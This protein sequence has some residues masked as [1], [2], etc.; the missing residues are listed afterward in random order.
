MKKIIML[1]SAVLMASFV[2]AAQ[3]KEFQIIL[4]GGP[5]FQAGTVTAITITAMDINDLKKDDF[6]GSVNI[7]STAGVIDVNG[8]GSCITTPFSSA[9]MDP[10]RW[11]G[12]IRLQGAASPTII[13]C[14]DSAGNLT[15]TSSA[16]QV[17]AGAF[18]KPLLIMDGMTWAP[19]TVLGYTGVAVTQTTTTPLFVTVL[20]V[21]A[22]NNTITSIF[23][24]VRITTNANHYSVTPTSVNMNVDLKAN[25]IFALALY[26]NPDTSAVY[27][28]NASNVTFTGAVTN[29]Q[30]V[31]FSSLSDYFVSA[32][33]PASAVAG[34]SFSVTVAVSH[35]APPYGIPISGL[36]D[37]V[38][39]AGI[40]FAGNSLNP[41]LQPV[42]EPN[43]SCTDGVKSF[44]VSYNK[45]SASDVT[46]IRISPFDI[47]RNANNAGLASR[48]SGVIVIY[49]DQPHSIEFTSALTKLKKGNKTLLSAKINDRFM[50]PVSNTAVDLS[51]TEGGGILIDS[52]GNTFTHMTV[53]T[54]LY[55]YVYVTIT[56]ESNTK[57]TASASVAGIALPSTVE[58]EFADVISSNSIGSYPNPFNPNQGPVTIEYYLNEDSDVSLKLYSF[59]GSTVWKKALSSGNSGSQKGYNQYIWDGITDRNMKIAAGLYTLKIEIKSASGKY[60][61][62]RKIAVK[63]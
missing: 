12:F 34:T 47:S 13:T 44:T 24:T 23:P 33:G 37:M 31:F 4:G 17:T 5:T 18:A 20:A 6:T 7:S 48:F 25:T 28:I 63:K 53:G 55:G 2:S 58:L 57:T 43:G 32:Q 46:G 41:G 45:S 35:F 51:V 62:T 61:L 54:N 60:T 11:T 21:D 14:Y 19:G 3:L 42:A 9:G 26:P 8:T 49:A 29:T 1:L 22:W 38:Q 15:G 40:D 30:S 39:I 16:I 27:D 50:N 56:A 10:G 52:L 59:N 36:N